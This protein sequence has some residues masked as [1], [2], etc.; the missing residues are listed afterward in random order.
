MMAPLL[1]QA[2][3]ALLLPLPTELRPRLYNTNATFKRLHT[4]SVK[5]SVNRLDRGFSALFVLTG[6]GSRLGKS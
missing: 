5:G 6:G 1:L 4:A 2:T 3:S